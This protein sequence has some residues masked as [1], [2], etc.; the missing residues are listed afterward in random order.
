[1]PAIDGERLWTPRLELFIPDEAGLR[2]SAGSA[3]ELAAA[4]GR[5]VAADWPPKEW[6]AGPV[7]YIAD[8]TSE[9]PEERFWRG[10]FVAI[11]SDARDNEPGPAVGTCGCKGPPGKDRAVEIGYS[12]VTS[13]WRRG[14]GSEATGALCAWAMRDPRV[15]L[16]RAH[17]L[18][19]DP[20]SAGV[21][22]RNQ[23]T[24]V[25]RLNDPNDGLVDRYE[26]LA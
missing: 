5:P 2:A 21:L 18:A 16:L 13:H 10:W 15:G 14:I 7:G 26:R 23:F 9:Q 20:A 1:M 11:R 3:A 12:I 24:L 8:R 6:D 17:T 4:L 22:L 25:Q 19:G